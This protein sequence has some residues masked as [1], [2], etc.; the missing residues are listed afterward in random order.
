MVRRAG[1]LFLMLLQWA[2]NPGGF[3][4]DRDLGYEVGKTDEGEVC[5]EL[6][7]IDEFRIA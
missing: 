4:G 3:S 2:G 7:T 6:D 5:R 1:Q